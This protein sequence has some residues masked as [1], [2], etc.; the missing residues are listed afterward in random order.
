MKKTNILLSLILVF[1][2]L[3]SGVSSAAGL[4]G[5]LSGLFSAQSGFTVVGDYVLDG[6]ALVSYNGQALHLTVPSTLG[7][8]EIGAEAFAQNNRLKTVTLPEGI[9]RVG[10]SAFASCY[11]LERVVLPESL[12]DIGGTVFLWSSLTEIVIPAAVLTIGQDAFYTGG[13]FT[14]WGQPGSEIERAAAESNVK[15]ASVSDMDTLWMESSKTVELNLYDIPY[16][17]IEVITTFTDQS[18]LYSLPPDTLWTS[19]NPAVAFVTASGV[20]VPVSPGVTTV[21]AV[22]GGQTLQCVLTVTGD[23]AVPVLALDTAYEVSLSAD[24]Y[25]TVFLFTP[26][27]SGN[28]VFTATGNERTYGEL[29]N[30]KRKS[31]TYKT[32]GGSGYNFAISYYLNAGET[33]FYQA[34]TYYH[35]AESFD[36][37]LTKAPDA[38]SIALDRQSISIP[39][40]TGGEYDYYWNRTTGAYELAYRYQLNAYDYY[41]EFSG[42]FLTTTYSD[43]EYE[44]YALQQLPANLVWKDYQQAYP[45]GV[46]EH[47]VVLEY[48][49]CTTTLTVEI[50]ESQIAGISASLTNPGATLMEYAD[51]GYL[52]NSMTFYYALRYR[53]EFSVTVTYKSGS[54]ETY[55]DPYNQDIRFSRYGCLEIYSFDGLEYPVYLIGDQSSSNQWAP[56]LQTMTALCAGKTDAFSITVT[57]NPID[58]IVVTTAKPVIP[59]YTCGWWGWSGN[60][61][62][63]RYN[64]QFCDLTLTVNYKDGSQ[65]V[66]H[67][68]EWEDNDH[69]LRMPGQ[70]SGVSLNRG[71]NQV[72]FEYGGFRT[73][74]EV[75]V[76]PT[77]I[78]RI[79][80][81]AAPEFVQHTNGQWRYNR[82]GDPYYF[83][84]INEEDLAFTV[85]YKDG[86]SESFT[87][88]RNWPASGLRILDTQPGRPWSF[89]S[90]TGIMEY[91]G[92]EAEFYASIVPGTILSIEAELANPNLLLETDGVWKDD[93]FQY[94]LGTHNGLTL[95]F[96]FEEGVSAVYQNLKIGQDEYYYEGGY[97]YQAQ[98]FYDTY[99]LDGSVYML[100]MERGALP[101]S[102]GTYNMVI[103]V[104]DEYNNYSLYT[105]TAAVTIV[106]EIAGFDVA[107]SDSIEEYTNGAW[108]NR[109]TSQNGPAEK[110]FLYDIPDLLTPVVHY[111]DGTSAPY[112]YLAEDINTALAGQQRVSPWS[113]GMNTVSYSFFGE[114][115]VFDIELTETSV[116]SISISRLPNKTT[117][118]LGLE[119]ISLD[120]LQ[121]LVQNRD[122]SS[123]IVEY[124]EYGSSGLQA[125]MGALH[126]GANTVTLQYAGE[127][128]TF[129]V[130]GVRF[131]EK[132]GAAPLIVDE[133]VAAE[134][135]W[136]GKPAYYCIVPEETAEYTFTTNT[137]GTYA[138][139]KAVL[140]DEDMNVIV[141]NN[142]T[143]A[144]QNFQI[145][146]YLEK[147]KPYLLA[148]KFVSSSTSG[149]ITVLTTKTTIVPLPVDQTTMAV[150]DKPG[151]F[152]KFV[153]TPED[154]VD[155]T[156]YSSS[157]SNTFV[158]LRDE[159]NNLLGT[160]D[161]SGDG[162]NF[163]ITRSFLNNLP[164]GKRY[165]IIVSFV[166]AS[167]TGTI[168]VTLTK[169]PVARLSTNKASEAII[170]AEGGEAWYVF[171]AGI[172]ADYTIAAA[173]SSKTAVT[174]VSSAGIGLAHHRPISG[175]FSLTY[176]LTAGE[177]YY[178]LIEFAGYDTGS[179]P[180]TFTADF[181][182]VV[183]G[184]VDSDG[185]VTA[186]DLVEVKKH[187]LNMQTLHEDVVTYCKPVSAD[188][189]FTVAD[190]V[191]MKK[192]VA[193]A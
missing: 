171:T 146:Q 72:M 19:S 108:A 25:G 159:D 49:G 180:F 40:Y 16:A 134:E 142:D 91:M 193:G 5:G 71:L 166:S 170:S 30:E 15:F 129:E 96:H 120:G 152:V 9:T 127:V 105:D 187:L 93:V 22:A 53:A 143:G 6:T 11:A 165:Y 156:V 17:D 124:Y 115:A 8:T 163:K 59:E 133:F 62:V 100:G 57:P 162:N 86:T 2:I 169:T 12:T 87:F 118:I 38:V 26:A 183:K 154:P 144:A 54:S 179:I 31:L 172:T 39:E 14:V 61:Q 43:G 116:Q 130:F 109:Q 44:S 185:V 45:W 173:T 47:E 34:G 88:A 174:L 182:Q 42:L 139:T 145:V 177:R 13:N 32:D 149:Q 151:G 136:Y 75:T 73:T 29:F 153:F 106:D 102:P 4:G 190:L 85:Y 70:E 63:Y 79:E 99:P 10:D 103:G 112:P 135:D 20:V 147:G 66:Y 107:V 155:Y 90:S 37:I 64:I 35:Y 1:S 178:F 3:L 188:A 77:D 104:Y 97:L 181:S 192:A 52:E 94:K 150:I 55:T 184:D 24:T 161:N 119:T 131:Y 58:N 140:Y 67:N 84:D 168:P 41:S 117:A 18:E 132:G 111:T 157:S 128:L 36:V 68:Y 114:E 56:G 121:I 80:V 60:T 81:T 92:V 33:Y 89:Y 76:V 23:A 110:F 113:L 98:S 78:D 141:S 175:D 28:Y 160:D 158:T 164:L 137:S 51:G 101:D 74:M 138:K 21:T 50:T 46:G 148:A 83:Y 191:R 122:G 126:L 167:E 186:L 176:T 69:F 125:E 189:D 65:S 48:M 27:V 82:W 7:L 95:T 123:Y